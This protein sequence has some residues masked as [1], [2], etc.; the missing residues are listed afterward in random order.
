MLPL[1]RMEA[2]LA[3]SDG[4]WKV[5]GVGWSDWSFVFSVQRQQQ[6]WLVHMHLY[7]QYTFTRAHS[8]QPTPEQTNKRA[9]AD[10]HTHTRHSA[11]LRANDIIHWT[12]A[13]T[14]LC[15]SHEHTTFH[16][17]ASIVRTLAHVDLLPLRLR[18]VAARAC[19]FPPK[20]T[21]GKNGAGGKTHTHTPHTECT[22]HTNN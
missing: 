18:D 19:P 17:H 12:F 13:Q 16:A 4:W 5:G 9:R 2:G 1:P 6:Q 7:G 22:Y 8:R 3:C 21:H 11:K 14:S 15:C 20:Y 10:T